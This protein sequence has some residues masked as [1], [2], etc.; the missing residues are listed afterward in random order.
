MAHHSWAAHRAC[1]DCDLGDLQGISQGYDIGTMK[2]IRKATTLM[3]RTG[4]RGC[5]LRLVKAGHLK[6]RVKA[7]LGL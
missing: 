3:P 7:F 4:P 1:K 2:D 5:D 6:L